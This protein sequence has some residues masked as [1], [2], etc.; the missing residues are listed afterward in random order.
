[1]MDLAKKG[2]RSF[3]AFKETSRGY[4]IEMKNAVVAHVN[5]TENSQDKKDFKGKV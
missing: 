1:M 2:L 3:L 4:F 5:K